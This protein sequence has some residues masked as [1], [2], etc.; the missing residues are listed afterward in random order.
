MAP[1]QVVDT[2]LQFK[3]GLKREALEFRNYTPPFH[4]LS[5]KILDLAGVISVGLSS[6]KTSQLRFLTDGCVGT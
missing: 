5:T 4:S 6:S 1:C 3:E 2:F